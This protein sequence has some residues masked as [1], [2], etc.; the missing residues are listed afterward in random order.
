MKLCFL[1]LGALL[2]S[3]AC[4]PKSNWKHSQIEGSSDEYNSSRL[5]YCLSNTHNTLQM[6]VIHRK[7]SYKGYLF[8]KGRVIPEAEGNPRLALVSLSIKGLKETY[9]VP[10]YEGGHRL[11]LPDDLLQKILEN[12]EKGSE[13]TLQV[14]GYLTTLDPNGFSSLYEKW[15]KNPYFHPF[16]KTS[17]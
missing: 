11:S 13:V 5:S 4:S 16:I 7:R 9:L 8:V 2:T 3:V 10:R 14:P 1:L 15:K 12:L 6:E 17:F